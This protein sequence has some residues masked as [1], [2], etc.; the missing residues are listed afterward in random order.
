MESFVY[1]IIQ[2]GLIVMHVLS[3]LVKWGQR[4]GSFPG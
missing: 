4:V 2:V 3:N 1:G